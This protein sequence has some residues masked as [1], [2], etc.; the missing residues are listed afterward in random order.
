M[1]FMKLKPLT[2]TLRLDK[3]VD[4]DN[5]PVEILSL[6]EKD[7]KVKYSFSAVRDYVVITDK[8]IIIEDKKG[9]RGFRRSFYTVLYNSISVYYIDVKDFDCT[10]NIIINSGHNLS[11]NF[12]KP[13][14]LNDM[15]EVYKY[16][17]N[18]I[19]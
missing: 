7:E 17:N 16:L 5:L 18:K 11:L 19:L 9:L 13:I 3:I 2:E 12:Y 1:A 14:P 6:L 4:R 8:R 15:F 10:I